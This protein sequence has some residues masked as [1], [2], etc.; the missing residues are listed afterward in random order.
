M[1]K[2]YFLIIVS[3]VISLFIYLF[4][5]T[6]KTVITD[7]FISLISLDRYVGLKESIVNNLI[8]NEHIINSLPEGLWVFCITLTSKNLFLK[9]RKKEINLLFLPLVFAI[10][11]EFF[12][13]FKLTNGRFDYWDIGFSIAFWAIANYVVKHE[14]S[15]QNILR[16]LNTNSLICILTYFIVYLAHVWE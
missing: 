14:N 16:P 7:L 8:L 1:K 15:R 2:K 9:I 12:Q 11:L 4:Y 10:G 5:R 3:L 13:L 6:E